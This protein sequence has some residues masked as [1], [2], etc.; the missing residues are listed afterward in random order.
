MRGDNDIYSYEI[1]MAYPQW[2]IRN[3]VAMTS[4]TSNCTWLPRLMQA[5]D[6]N[7][8]NDLKNAPGS[9]FRGESGIYGP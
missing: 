2:Y 7:D 6:D 5:R 4:T 3:Q 8:N 9:N 1:V